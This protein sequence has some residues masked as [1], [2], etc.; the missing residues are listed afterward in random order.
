LVK[1]QTSAREKG[2]PTIILP[3]SQPDFV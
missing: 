3:L 1:E 2:T